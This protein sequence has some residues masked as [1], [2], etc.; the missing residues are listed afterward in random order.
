M[1]ISY[2]MSSLLANVIANTSPELSEIFDHA[3][4]TPEPI[5]EEIDSEAHMRSKR[6]MTAKS[7]YNDFIVYLVYDT[8]KIIVA[9]FASLDADDWKEMVR[10]EM[11][12]I[13]YNETWKLVD[14]PYGCKPVSCK[15]VFKKK[16]RLDDTIG[17]YKTSLVTKCYT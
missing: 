11:D 6:S 2:G 3:K 10:S 16:L 5:Y 14:R 17:K 8:P 12:S 1:K 15:W 13:L 9:A 7:F 4:H